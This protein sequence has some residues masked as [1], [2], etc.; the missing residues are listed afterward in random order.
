M[1]PKDA[2]R[3]GRYFVL[4]G[5]AFFL[6]AGFTIE[7]RGNDWMED[8]KSLYYSTRC[9]LQ[10][11]D[12]YSP[13]EVSKVY[14]REAHED[15]NDAFLRGQQP[16]IT[17]NVYPPAALLLTAPL[18]LLDWGPAHFVWMILIAICSVLSSYLVWDLAADDSPLLSGILVGLQLADGFGALLS[19][20]PAGVVVSLCIVSVWCFLRN[21]FVFAGVLS[22]AI[23]L[24]VKPHDAWLIWLCL[25]VGG[26]LLRRRAWQTVF[27][28]VL[29]NLSALLWVRQSAPHWI[30][31]FFSN[32]ATV[33]GPAGI[34]NPA[35]SSLS[36]HTAGMIVDLQTVF[37]VF[38][39]DPHFYNR[40]SYLL[41]SLVLAVWLFATLRSSVARSRTLLSFAALS[42][43]TMLPVY[44]RTYDARLLLLTI[45]A[46]AMVWAERGARRW[47]ALVASLAGVIFTGDVVLATIVWATGKMHFSMVT[48]QDKARLILWTRPL[49]LLLL[50]I[51]CFYMSICLRWPRRP[52]QAGDDRPDQQPVSNATSS[53]PALGS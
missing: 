2:R 5:A 40:A 12:A 3:D 19:G 8:F 30:P 45:P 51:G 47:L 38:N 48:L 13:G 24:S 37:S 35:P 34:N 39:D 6:L 29:L 17:I 18:A 20:N 22:L 43:F 27:C 21:R 28:A 44:H 25:F 33:S 53:A 52:N 15:P 32:L 31:E 4:L 23:S 7:H 16:I 36:T 42:S 11:Q 49:P 46:F 50:A 1:N 10:Q 26:S 9:L 41:F 14:S